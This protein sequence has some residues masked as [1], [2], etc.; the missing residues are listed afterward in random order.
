MNSHDFSV[1]VALVTG[2]TAG[3]G[4]A[5]ALGLGK[6]GAK[7][8]LTGI[9]DEDGQTVV[10]EIER[11]GGTATYLA[12]TL[13]D[14]DGWKALHEAAAAV[15]GSFSVFVHSAS[16]QR[17]EDQTV[18]RVTEEQWDTMINT[19]LRSGFFLAQTIAKKM[20]AE[21]LLGRMVFMT[22][23]HAET[24]RNL[25]HYSA[26]KAGQAMVV[27]ELARALGGDGIRVNGIAP[28]AVPGGGFT[29]DP[30]PLE[31][32]IPMGRC[33]TPDDIAAATLALLSHEHCGYVNGAILAVDG[34]LE[35]YNWI[36]R[37]ATLD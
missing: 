3:I 24:P 23:L 36:Q 35:G 28:G 11:A 5:V 32:L 18:L 12:G 19:N 25:P 26:A 7:T 4:R 17:K 22:S 1:D 9:G 34:G 20:R 14:K 10:Q 30:G 33:G 29:A 13:D 2:A 37:P 21:R 8:V 16:P 15:Y 27:R 6:A 31:A